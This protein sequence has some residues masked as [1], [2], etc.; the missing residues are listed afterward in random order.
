[1]T[2]KRNWMVSGPAIGLQFV[3]MDYEISLKF[4]NLD[5]NLPGTRKPFF[6]E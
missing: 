1:M 3:E 5:L 2:E 6:Q 4:K